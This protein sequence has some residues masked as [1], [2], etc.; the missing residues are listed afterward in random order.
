[1]AGCNYLGY[2]LSQGLG[3]AT[4]TITAQVIF[5]KAC[6]GGNVSSCASLGSLFEN[7]GDMANAR[8]Y[9][10]IACDRH[11]AQGCELLRNVR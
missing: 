3:G 2:L 7:A 8:K 9:F 1:M 5:T 11:S 6:D 4:D 10:Q